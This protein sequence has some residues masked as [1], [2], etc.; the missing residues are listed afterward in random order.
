MVAQ[1]TAE[2]EYVSI[3]ATANQAIWLR[4]L[5]TDLGMKQSLPTELF[6]DN[7]SAI[8]IAENPVQHGRTK[9][10]NVKYHSIREAERNKEV[11]VL[12]CSSE[13]QIADMMTKALPRI[14]LEFL[15]LKLGM[16]K[17][18]LKEEC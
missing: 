4:K 8:A 2:A 9:H 1:S 15:K 18:N 6:C 17:Q 10:I 11:K 5:L 3:S 12:H 13:L 14:R 16:S 7:K